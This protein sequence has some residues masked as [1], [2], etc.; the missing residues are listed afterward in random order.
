MLLLLLHGHLTILL[1]PATLL[2][3]HRCGQR[4]LLL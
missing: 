4:T 1:V 3:F 2:L